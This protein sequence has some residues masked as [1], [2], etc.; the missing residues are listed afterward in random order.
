MMFE[1]LFVTVSHPLAPYI[2]SL[3][4]RFNQCS[5]KE[6]V[7][8]KE[9]IDPQSRFVYKLFLICI[10]GFHVYSILGSI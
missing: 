7:E 3:Y 1:M 5:A 4:D 9:K 10:Y 2:F 8:V 6:R